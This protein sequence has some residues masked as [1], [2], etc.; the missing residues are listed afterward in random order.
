MVWIIFQIKHLGGKGE[1]ADLRFG[2]SNLETHSKT[3]WHRSIDKKVVQGF[4]FC[5]AK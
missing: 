4:R 5:L 3:V 2:V 1:P